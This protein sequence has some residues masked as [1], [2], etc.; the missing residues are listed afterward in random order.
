MTNQKVNRNKNVT[1]EDLNKVF[2]NLTTLETLF[3]KEAKLF[4]QIGGQNGHLHTMDL[5]TS[6]IINRSISLMRGF[7]TLANENNYISAV[8]LIRIQL[9][10]CLRFYASTLV[11]D[12][13]KFFIEYLKGVHI[14]NLKDAA[15]EKLTDT[16][17]SKKL[18]KVFPGLHNLYVN[19]SGHVHLSNEHSFMQTEIVAD[20]ERTIG[21]RIGFYDFF[22]IDEKVD[23]TYNMF[24]ASEI[25]LE[26]TR[27]WKFQ[28]MKVE[29]KLKQ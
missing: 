21:T 27:S 15:G 11:S 18:D 29:N 14:R 1:E 26:L 5:F 16:Y 25:L 2:T 9:D 8:P 28:K 20:K 24:K 23:F 12:Y 10:N 6:A 19:T 13:N 17:L 22:E 4:F 7:R 3:I